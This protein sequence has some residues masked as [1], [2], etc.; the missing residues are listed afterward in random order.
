VKRGKKKKNKEREKKKRE[1]IK[2][3]AGN[4]ECGVPGMVATL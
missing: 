4:I 2:R 3:R 1:L